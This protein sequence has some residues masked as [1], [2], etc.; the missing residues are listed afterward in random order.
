M[1]DAMLRRLLAARSVT[2]QLIFCRPWWTGFGAALIVATGTTVL[3]KPQPRLIWNASASAPIGL[4]SVTPD[5]PLRR[6]DMVAARLATPWRGFAARRHYL[7]ANV[8]LIKRVAAIAGDQIC[9]EGGRILVNGRAVA[10]AL[11]RDGAG[12]SMPRWQGCR[13]LGDDMVLLLNDPPASFDGR[14]FGPTSRGDIIGKASPLW[15]R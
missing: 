13:L 3:V 9:A 12:R 4:W 10:T 1:R 15:L 2:R 6:S 11:S 8:P 14:Y 7:P 5:A